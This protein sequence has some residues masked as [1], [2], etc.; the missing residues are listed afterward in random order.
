MKKR[1]VIAVLVVAL[2]L[3]ATTLWAAELNNVTAE[4]QDGNLVYKD[5]SGN[6]INKWDAAN[7]AI[8]VPSGSAINIEDGGK[9]TGFN[10][11]LA[12]SHVILA[13]E[14]WVLSTAEAVCALLTTSSGSHASIIAPDTSGKVYIVRNAGLGTVTIK[15]SGGSGVSI[16]T[17]KTAIVLHNGSD[18]VRVTADATH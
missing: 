17:G 6:I 1:S 3:V 4:G 18:Y 9:I 5:V 15:K 2:L 14:D 7:R 8:V 13:V 16:A 10:I 12:A 11:G